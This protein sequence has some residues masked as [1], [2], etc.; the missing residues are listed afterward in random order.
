MCNN[1]IGGF[2]CMCKDGYWGDGIIC[3]GKLVKYIRVLY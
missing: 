2:I 3:K 1:I